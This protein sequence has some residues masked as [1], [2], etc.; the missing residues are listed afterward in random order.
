MPDPIL[1]KPSDDDDKAFELEAIELEPIA[2]PPAAGF[3][4]EENA[5]PL[6]AEASNAF[7]RPPKELVGDVVPPPEPPPLTF[8]TAISPPTPARPAILTLA[9]ATLA[10]AGLTA[11]YFVAQ[12]ENADGLR[13]PEPNWFHRVARFMLVVLAAGIH[14][15]TGL[16]AA[17]F[18]AKIMR[19]QIG[20]V[21][22]TVARM[23]L[24]VSAFLFVVSFSIPVPYVGPLLKAL[25][26]GGAYYGLIYLL[27]GRRTDR[28]NILLAMH[29]AIA[30]LLYFHTQLYAFVA[31]VVQ[32]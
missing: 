8:D 7:V 10:L 32:K 12:V 16:A 30:G 1:P 22:A 6:N 11:A 13:G 18:A 21:A 9:I 26:A 20:S 23:G 27:F 31:P 14:T 28:A 5:R 17:Y 25:L 19:L 15:T 4:Q 29:A 2:P 3:S 24:A